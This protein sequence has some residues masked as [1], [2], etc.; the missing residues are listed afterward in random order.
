MLQLCYYDLMNWKSIK[1]KSIYK[2]KRKRRKPKKSRIQLYADKLNKDLP[3]SEVW[4]QDLFKEHRISTGIHR[5]RDHYNEPIGKYIA[6]L[7]N[8]K[9]KYIVEID[10]SM[11][12]Q[13]LIKFK[14]QVKDLYLTKRGY[15]V[16]RVKAFNQSEYENAVNQILKLRQG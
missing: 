16:I 14:D 1:N 6:D 8:Y 9:Y 10:G 4:F 7:L 11:H 3:K 15:T 13:E 5:N 12:D 2:I